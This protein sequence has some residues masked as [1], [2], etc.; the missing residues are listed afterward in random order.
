[1]NGRDT[2]TDRRSYLK[3]LAGLTTV[4]VAGCS[5]DGGDGEDGGGGDGGDG[6]NGDLPTVDMSA[7]AGASFGQLV[8]DVLKG[9]EFDH[10]ND[11]NVEITEAGP[12][13]V[14]QLV[15]NGSVDTGFGNPT[16][17]ATARTEGHEVSIYGPWNANHS[18]LLAPPDSDVEG[19]EDLTGEQIGIL[20]APSGIWNHTKMLLAERG[21]DLEQDF[22]TRTGAP[23]A[24]Q[25]WITGGDVAAGVLFYPLIVPAL[26]EGDLVEVGFIPDML[27]ES[28]G[29][30]YDFVNLI[31][32]DGWLDDNPDLAESTQQAMIDAH[33][34]I[35]NN[36]VE[37]L[38]E[39]G[40]DV[41]VESEEEID[42][43]A[44]KLPGI[45]PGWDTSEAQE[46]IQEQLEFVKE[47]GMLPEDA[48]TDIVADI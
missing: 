30:V 25:S 43:M 31:A 40:A 17:M 13:E 28:F 10:Q 46:D 11:V 7:T 39:Y 29:R 16:G 36:P 4:G 12:A 33:G 38:E 27:E 48:P 32:L 20:G 41:T 37:V 1:M 34:Y 5:G 2:P 15:I 21:W 35:Q 45:V 18:S 19:W 24:I 47:L 42:L 3:G 44:E 23:P 26:V 9:E 6:G 22:E 14:P 8:A